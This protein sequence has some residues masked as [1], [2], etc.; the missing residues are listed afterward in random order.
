M[1][2]YGCSSQG[3]PLRL[4]DYRGSGGIWSRAAVVDNRAGEMDIAGSYSVR[5]AVPGGSNT[6]V[7]SQASVGV[8]GV[9]DGA[10]EHVSRRRG[11]CAVSEG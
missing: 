11:A 10:P 5:V 6:A 2:R 7:D 8:R 3:G 9:L 4:V 1:R